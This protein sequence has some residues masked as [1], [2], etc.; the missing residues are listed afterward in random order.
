MRD[1]RRGALFA[2]A[3]AFLFWSTTSMPGGAA[4][5]AS[6]WLV[7]LPLLFVWLL[8]SEGSL[9]G[10]YRVIDLVA[11]AG[12]ALPLV[13]I[14]VAGSDRTMRVPPPVPSEQAVAVEELGTRPDMYLIVLDGHGRDDELAEY[15]GI[16]QGLGAALEKRGF[17]AAQ[18]SHAN[19]SAT[20]Q[21]LPLPRTGDLHRSSGP[22]S[23]R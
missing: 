18:K 5:A 2:S 10:I 15:F 4:L 12:V 14:T 7:S 9:T 8:R 21:A 16:E 11:A 23:G 13:S 19:Y 17:Y 1:V 3:V 6:V 20:L 22:A